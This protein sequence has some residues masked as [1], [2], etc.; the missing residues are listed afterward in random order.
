MLRNK[1]Q[2]GTAT[3]QAA[4]PSKPQPIPSLLAL[5]PV[6]R[7]PLLL[8]TPAP[9]APRTSRAAH[10]DLELNLNPPSTAPRTP[11]RLPDSLG[12]VENPHCQS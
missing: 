8:P 4:T 9:G 5:L 12:S 3:S 2:S 7:T 6:P 1:S 10:G 11:L